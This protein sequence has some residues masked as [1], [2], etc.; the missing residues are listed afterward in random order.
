MAPNPAGNLGGVIGR[1]ARNAGALAEANQ[2]TGQEASVVD[3]WNHAVAGWKERV[4]RVEA[5]G[6]GALVPSGAEMGR[7]LNAMAPGRWD[8]ATAGGVADSMAAQAAGLS[9]AVAAIGKA[10]GALATTGA[11]LNLVTSAEQ[12]LSTLVSF[13]PF[14]SLPAVRITDLAFGLPHSHAHWPFLTLPS[15]GPVLPIPVLSGATKTLINGLPAARCGD[16]GVGVWCG[17]WFPFYE[18]F[19][20]SSSVWVEGARSARI[21]VDITKHCI[22][23]VPKP[24]DPPLGPT[25]GTPVT[26]SFNTLIG[27]VPLPSL[28]SMLLGAVLKKPLQGLAALA[29]KAGGLFRRVFKRKPKL[30]PPPN[31]ALAEACGPPQKPW[32]IRDGEGIRPASALD[33]KPGQPMKLDPNDSKTYLYVVK[34]DGTITYAPQKY[35]PGGV[36]DELVKHTDLAENGPARVSGEIKYDDATDTWVMDNASGR[37]SAD[38]PFPGGPI[39]GTRTPENVD[40][41]VQLAKESG[42]SNNIVPRFQ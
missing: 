41:A 40:A 9:D 36:H 34:E 12:L 23:T 33:A 18:I 13:I 3:G 35:G 19:L 21:G 26:A 22:F 17:G 2:R 38:R 5:E 28:T 1:G 14:P 29:K 37:Y 24:T 8:S 4:A 10:E 7:A 20:G 31:R 16:M 27:G 6:L 32:M 42:T 25:I 11:V 15:L 30:P 39:I